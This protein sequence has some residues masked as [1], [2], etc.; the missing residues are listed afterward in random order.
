MSR[1]VQP[2]ISRAFRL[3]WA[4]TVSVALAACSSSKTNED[5]E[6][7]PDEEVPVADAGTDAVPL[8]SAEDPNAAPPADGTVAAADPA[9]DPAATP[10]DPAAAG[11]DPM[12]GVDNGGQAAPVEGQTTTADAQTTD[13]YATPATD[14]AASGAPVEGSGGT[15]SYSFKPGDTL[16]KIAFETYGDLYQWRK[17]LEANRDVITDPNQIPAGTTLKLERPASPVSISRN[18]E[19]YQIRSGDTLGTISQ[20]VY[21]TPSKWRDI[22]DNNR[23]LIKDPNKIYAGFTLYYLPAGSANSLASSGSGAATTD[24]TATPASPGAAEPSRQPAGAD[25]SAPADGAAVAQ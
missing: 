21:G 19:A 10:T 11:A 25:S 22:W 16:M 23:E 1:S 13:P 9:A 2:Q 12:A 17:I 18:G 24:S 8:A 6:V 5:G 3:A 7:S 20:Q 15:E 14:P 4:V